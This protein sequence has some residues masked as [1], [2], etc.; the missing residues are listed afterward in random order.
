MVSSRTLYTFVS[1]GF[2][3]ITGW[4]GGQQPVSNKQPRQ[5]QMFTMQQDGSLIEIN[6]ETAAIGLDQS[7]L[8]NTA[9]PRNTVTFA[10]LPG[11]RAKTRYAEGQ[12]IQIIALLP[13]SV[14]PRQLELQSFENHG[15]IRVAYLR[16]FGSGPGKNWNTRSF[17][18]QPLKDGSWLL[19]PSQLRPGEYCFSPRFN[20]DN[21]CFGVDKK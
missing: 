7:G 21:F 16:P 4:A 3:W 8:G 17:H 9:T 14:D 6:L 11:D 12:A 2:L 20:N 5:I 10:K 1:L 19:E 13:R 18:A 15:K